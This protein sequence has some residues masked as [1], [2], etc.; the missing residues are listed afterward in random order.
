MFFK[1]V[2]TKT[3]GKPTVLAFMFPHQIKKHDD[4]QDYIVSI[5]LIEAMTG[6]DFLWDLIGNDHPLGKEVAWVDFNFRYRPPCRNIQTGKLVSNK[7]YFVDLVLHMCD[8]Y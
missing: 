8:K 3:D 2:L 7:C 6:L 4:I 5:N 1:I